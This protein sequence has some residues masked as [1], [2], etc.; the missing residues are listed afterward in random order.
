MALKFNT[1]IASKPPDFSG[2]GKIGTKLGQAWSKEK[3]NNPSLWTDDKGMFQGGEQNRIFGRARDWLESDPNADIDIDED[4]ILDESED[5]IL[6][7]SNDDENIKKDSLLTRFY[8]WAEQRKINKQNGVQNIEEEDP[9]VTIED[10]LPNFNDK[11]QVS[12]PWGIRTSAS[13]LPIAQSQ[14]VSDIS[15]PSVLSNTWEYH[16][17]NPN[18]INQQSGTLTPTFNVNK[19][20]E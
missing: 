5:P 14:Y 7:E 12:S 1:P 13:R 19:W 17:N 2:L 11:R 20:S 18:S 16:K 4:P 10:L 9:T 6:D 3:G 15:Q 8:N